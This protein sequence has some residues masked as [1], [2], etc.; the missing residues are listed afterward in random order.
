MVFVNKIFYKKGEIPFLCRY[1]L[2]CVVWNTE[3]VILDESNLFGEEMSD[4]YV[5]G[6]YGVLSGERPPT[7]FSRISSGGF[8]ES[9]RSKKPTFI[10]GTYMTVGPS[11]C[12]E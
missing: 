5:S 10:T 12:I 8:E 3:E 9:T 4:I 11:Q 7:H 6:Y 2:R 1:V